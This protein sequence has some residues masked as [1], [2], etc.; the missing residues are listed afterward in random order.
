MLSLR[1]VNWKIPACIPRQPPKGSPCSALQRPSAAA[2]FSGASALG[3]PMHQKK[4]GLQRTGPGGALRLAR[5][6]AD[7]LSISQRSLLPGEVSFREVGGRPWMRIKLH[8]SPSNILGNKLAQLQ[9][10]AELRRGSFVCLS[11]LFFHSSLHVPG[12]VKGCPT[13]S[14]DEG[15]RYQPASPKGTRRAFSR[16]ARFRRRR[17]AQEPRWRRR[18][19]E[20][21]T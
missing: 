21:R 10:I 13:G 20:P 11:L 14:G 8:S 12:R 9:S 19:A 2:E 3:V 6:A 17:R 16:A 18:S 4:E 5:A 7:L 15:G 1:L